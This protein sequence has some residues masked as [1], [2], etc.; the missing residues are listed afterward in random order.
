MICTDRPKIGALLLQAKDQQGFPAAGRSSR[1][2]PKG[3]GE[4]TLS[5][6]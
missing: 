4:N 2:S 6:T 5:D 1:R 3:F